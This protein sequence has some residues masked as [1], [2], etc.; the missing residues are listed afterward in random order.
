MLLHIGIIYEYLTIFTGCYTIGAEL[1]I[2]CLIL[3]GVP[4]K[5]STR[6]VW[7]FFFLFLRTILYDNSILDYY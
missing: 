7:H 3:L 6:P 4:V 5:C 2:Y 1:L